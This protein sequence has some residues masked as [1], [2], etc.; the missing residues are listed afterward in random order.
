MSTIDN[1]R[2][3][4][5]T[6]RRELDDRLQRIRADRQR[7]AGPLSAD[8]AEQATELENEDVLAR[9]EQSTAADLA[10]VERALHREAEGHYGICERCGEVIEE[11]R[12]KA[13]PQAT[14]CSHCA[15]EEGH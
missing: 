8:S 4:L 5:Q 3:R 7:R 14:L 2:P 13:L 6:L 12:L 15:G 9:L 11:P 1:P 10:Q